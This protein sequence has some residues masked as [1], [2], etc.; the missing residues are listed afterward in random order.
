M[1]VVCVIQGTSLSEKVTEGEEVAE[2]PIH[3]PA[4]ARLA[5]G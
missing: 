5:R 1:G 3:P 4:R 2:L